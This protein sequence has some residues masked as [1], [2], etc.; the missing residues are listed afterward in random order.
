MNFANVVD[1]T[2]V[3]S[4]IDEGA[5]SPPNGGRWFWGKI[6]APDGS[7]G[8]IH[9][10]EGKPVRKPKMRR[11]ISCGTT[12][13][14]GPTYFGYYSKGDTVEPLDSA[15]KGDVCK[16]CLA[17]APHKG[18]YVDES[19]DG[20]LYFSEPDAPLIKSREVER[21]EEE[22]DPLG[23]IEIIFDWEE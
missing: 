11:G 5:P 6:I 4:L 9:C 20:F 10:I 1:Q 13:V 14:I 7:S 16:K 23:P 3:I 15:A 12:S 22:D 21:V 8:K 18:V 17:G 2:Q 19:L